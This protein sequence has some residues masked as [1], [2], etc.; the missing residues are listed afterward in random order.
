MM[1]RGILRST[2]LILSLTLA[3]CGACFGQDSK[4]VKTLASRLSTATHIGLIEDERLGG[5]TIMIYSPDQYKLNLES[6][7]KYRADLDAYQSTIDAIDR[8]RE[9]AVAS[10]SSVDQL[11]AITFERNSHQPPY[12]QF[13]QGRISLC[14]IVDVASDYIEI[15]RIANT[16]ESTLIPLSK[17]CSVRIVKPVKPS[18]PKSE[19][20]NDK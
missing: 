19:N 9:V 18:V 13:V 17:I 12:S 7:E 14:R 15:S 2:L 10:K 4:T 5:Y 16:D 20:G 11:N 3:S 6:L 1:E 8:R